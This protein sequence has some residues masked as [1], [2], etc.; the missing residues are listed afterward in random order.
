M[1]THTLAIVFLGWLLVGEGYGLA[2][3]VRREWQ[4]DVLQVVGA[5]FAYWLVASVL[6]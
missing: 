6:L 5:V 2:K 4:Y 3:R 1:S